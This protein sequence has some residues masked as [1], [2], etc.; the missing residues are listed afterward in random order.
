MSPG[1]VF[2]ISQDEWEA[3]IESSYDG[4]VICNREGVIEWV[5][6]A[7]E[8][9]TGI[10]KESV[11]GKKGKD[12]VAQGILSD[13]LADKILEAK[14]PLALVQT[15][16]TGKVALLI[17]N[18][19]FNQ[20][21]EITR[22]VFNV[23]DI[24]EINLLRAKLNEKLALTER[25]REELELLR[26]KQLEFPA[27]IAQ[28]NSMKQLLE[29]VRTV[30]RVDTTILILG[31]SGVG[32]GEVAKLIH[33]MSP[34]YEGPFIVVNCAAIPDSL[35]ESELFGYEKGAFSGA[36]KEGKPGMF[37]LAH[38]GTL[39][40]DE[41]GDL[42]LSLQAKLLR[43]LQ[44][45]EFI[46]LGGV[47][48]VKVDVRIIAATNANL[49]EK[50]RQGF[51]RKDLYYR[52][53]V[54]PVTVPPL[55][56][57]KEDIYPLV[58]HFMERIREKYG[59]NKTISQEVMEIFYDYDWPGNVRELENLIERLAVTTSG[60]VIK[61]SDLPENLR[62]VKAGKKEKERENEGCA[63]LKEV[64]EGAEGRVLLEL[65]N[66]YKSTYKVARLLG[67]SQSTAYRK[68]RYYLNKYKIGNIATSSP[69][70]NSDL[71]Q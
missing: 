48:P 5:N 37:E 69:A 30:A 53:H 17:G 24:T 19:L 28:S 9:I 21:G 64:V 38:R 36:K 61:A 63:S 6:T 52:L 7:Y 13:Y 14:K 70:G 41:I 2:F 18:P 58:E 47:K 57:R 20:E 40:L 68:I 46:R 3:I 11:I 29:L 56:E 59:I 55:R 8:R 22:I 39:F 12:L 42:S 60:K 43:V 33:K 49:E 45:R 65:F 23:R 51:F 54:V 32:K 62:L 50:V 67:I 4:I 44:D 34:R 16:N 35:L 25:Y 66:K 15:Y 27:F 26:L 31:E 1:K 71:N 10:S